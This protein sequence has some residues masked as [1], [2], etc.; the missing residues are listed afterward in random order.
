MKAIRFFLA[1]IF[2]M[3]ASMVSIHA[4]AQIT[5]GG[6]QMFAQEYVYDFA[7]HGGAVGF[8]SLKGMGANA[9]PSGAVLTSAHYMVLTAFTSGGSATVA[10]G[11]AAGGAK[12]KAATAYNDSSYTAST[13]VAV[14]I[15]LPGLVSSANIANV[16]ITVATAALTGGKMRIVL[17][18]YVPK[19]Q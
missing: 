3:F 6:N 18:G 11:D 13:P 5:A 12:Y 10:L 1:S 16:G 4:Q 14:A 19:G 2:V 15:G 7:K 8:I 17:M 9:L